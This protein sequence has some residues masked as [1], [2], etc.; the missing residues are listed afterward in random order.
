[1][2]LL[3]E[4]KKGSSS[5]TLPIP[6]VLPRRGCGSAPWPRRGASAMPAASRCGCAAPLGSI[7][8]SLTG[9]PPSSIRRSLPL[10]RMR[11]VVRSRAEPTQQCWSAWSRPG[12]SLRPAPHACSLVLLPFD[13]HQLMPNASRPTSC[14]RSS[15]S[16]RRSTSRRPARSPQWTPERARRL[17]RPPCMA[18]ARVTVAPQHLTLACPLADKRIHSGRVDPQAAASA[19]AG[20]IARVPGPGGLQQRQSAALV[21]G[22]DFSV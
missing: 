7:S 10:E 19:P 3:S 6:A 12:G 14:S 9:A 20:A 18:P 15:T 17:P 5:I 22:C 16:G 4:K 13:D 21:V 11:A 2:R 1:M 8:T